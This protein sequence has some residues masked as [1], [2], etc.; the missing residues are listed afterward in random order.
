M[1]RLLIMP[2]GYFAGEKDIRDIVDFIFFIDEHATA[3]LKRVE[4]ES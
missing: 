3:I 1:E 4:N 2:S